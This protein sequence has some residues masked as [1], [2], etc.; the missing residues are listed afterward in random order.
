MVKQDVLKDKDWSERWPVGG[1]RAGK[2]IVWRSADG[3][4]GR[5]ESMGGFFG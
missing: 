5:R 3:W 2:R 4:R 1:K